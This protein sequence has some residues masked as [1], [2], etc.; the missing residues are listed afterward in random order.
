[1]TKTAGITALVILALT[2][3]GVPMAVGSVG[4]DISP[5]SSLIT[6]LVIVAA[7]YA[8][9]GIYNLLR[10][11]HG[12]GRAIV[13]VSTGAT[14]IIGAGCLLMLA[15][16]ARFATYYG[17][18]ERLFSRGFVLFIF[19]AG[20]ICCATYLTTYAGLHAAAEAHGHNPPKEPPAAAPPLNN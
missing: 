13:I 20:L 14:T 9:W 15:M 2:A 18:A 19:F 5:T 11:K 4:Y 6:S 10:H 17:G 1:M 12:T 7:S 8:A 3:I 16:L